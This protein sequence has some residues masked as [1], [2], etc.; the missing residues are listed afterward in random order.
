MTKIIAVS[1][2]KG[3]VG[4][5]T[6]AYTLQHALAERGKN[7]I[8][9]DLDPQSSLTTM[10]GVKQPEK[11]VADSMT[12]QCENRPDA[13]LDCLVGIGNNWALA[14]A[15]ILLSEIE[16]T[17][18]AQRYPGT[19]LRKALSELP[20]IDY[21][22]IDCLPSLGVL[23]FNALIA[24]QQVLIPTQPEGVAVRAM[25]LLFRA[26]EEAREGN[27]NL[28]IL[29]ILPT[30]VD[31]RTVLHAEVIK[32]MQEY[33]WPVLEIFVTRSIKMAEAPNLNQSILVYAPTSSQARAYRN[34][35]ELIDG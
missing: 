19:V 28:K 6:T 4:K 20:P 26:I 23:A 25:P 9:I 14:P 11:T 29:G 32:A 5:T 1:N 3:G 33:G 16:R 2:Q 8:I 10:Y 7:G 15:D 31:P 22:L 35:A 34:L 24:A 30:M 27:P 17:L 21:V 13:F 12:L 18:P